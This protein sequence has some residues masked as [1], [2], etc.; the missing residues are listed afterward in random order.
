MI[1]TGFLE[2]FGYK[3]VKDW[4]NDGID[5]TLDDFA[6]KTTIDQNSVR[7]EGE[8]EMKQKSA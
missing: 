2:R 4:Q 8:E 7:F 3:V 1:E 5:K 6:N